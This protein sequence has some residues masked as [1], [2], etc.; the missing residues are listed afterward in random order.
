MLKSLKFFNARVIWTNV[1]CPVDYSS[2]SPALSEMSIFELSSSW[3][4]DT[5]RSISLFFRMVESLKTSSLVQLTRWVLSHCFRLICFNSCLG[6]EVTGHF[7]RRE[8]P[9]L[10]TMTLWRFQHSFKQQCASENSEALNTINRYSRH[11]IV[12]AWI[13]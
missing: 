10:P 11:K 12:L 13:D 3:C 7:A 8:K 5:L 1:S 9:V 2:A 4:K 6:M